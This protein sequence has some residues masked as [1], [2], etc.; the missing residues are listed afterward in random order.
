MKVKYVKNIF[1]I[2]YT[3]T[4]IEE[5]QLLCIFNTLTIYY[6]M[7]FSFTLTLINVNVK[8]IKMYSKIFKV[9]NILK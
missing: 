3:I 6:Y 5:I 1:N 9:L 7:L 4:A 2:K 8:I